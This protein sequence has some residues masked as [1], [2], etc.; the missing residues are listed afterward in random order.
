MVL[1]TAFVL[2]LTGLKTGDASVLVPVAQMGF[3]VTALLGFAF[4][5]EAFNMRKGVGLLVA[6]AAMLCLARG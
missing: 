4:L 6:L 5:G 1:S 3:V 2:L